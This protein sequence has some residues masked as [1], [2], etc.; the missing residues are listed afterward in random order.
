MRVLWSSGM[1][2]NKEGCHDGDHRDTGRNL[3]TTHD[4]RLFAR[5]A[6]EL[7]AVLGVRAAQRDRPSTVPGRCPRGVERRCITKEA[8]HDADLCALLRLFGV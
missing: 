5:W 7:V 3:R 1:E 2:E 8:N 6:P 4:P